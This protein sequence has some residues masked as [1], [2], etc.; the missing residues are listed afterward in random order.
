M[1]QT[2]DAYL[3]TMS[4]PV[5]M[6]MRARKTMS[7]KL[8]RARAARRL[9]ARRRIN[10]TSLAHAIQQRVRAAVPMQPMVRFAM[11]ATRV[12]NP[13]LAKLARARAARR[14]H[15]RRRI[16]ATSPAH[17]IRQQVPATIP[18]RPMVRFAM[19]ATRVHN[20][21]PAKL[22][23]ARGQTRSPAMRRINATSPA[24]AI[25]QRALVAILQ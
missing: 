15:A 3:P 22:E 21:I 19:I 13:I 8:A 14:L 23:R 25:Q 16:N 9:H 7:A 11:I 17:A 18:M 20:P 12:H 6:A 4:Q 5:T 1:R 10:A 24:H 2:V